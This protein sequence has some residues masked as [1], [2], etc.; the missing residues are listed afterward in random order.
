[1]TLS[2]VSGSVPLEL[3]H[4]SIPTLRGFRGNIDLNLPTIVL[5]DGFPTT[6]QGTVT[7]NNV[8]AA[9]LSPSPV[10]NYAAEFSS[11]ENGIQGVVRDL[12]GV[13]SVNGDLTFTRDRAYSLV[14]QVALRPDA[15]LSLARQIEMLGS[16]DAQGNREFR[17]EGQ[18]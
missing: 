12:S 18:L 1:M 5:E 16:P 14:G 8:Q 7:V 15:P 9:A 2:E 10:G 3:L 13:L 11:D 17:I 6:I 4:Q